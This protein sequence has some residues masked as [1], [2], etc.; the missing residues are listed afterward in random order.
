MQATQP[1]QRAKD[2]NLFSKL[3]FHYSPY[4]PLFLIFLVLSVAGAWTYLRFTT[5]IFESTAR[6]LIKDEK[7]GTE[8]SKALESL[9]ML[10]TKK[11]IENEMEVIQSRSLLTDVVNQLGLYGVVTAKGSFKDEDL[12]TSS[13]LKVKAE[14]PDLIVSAKPLALKLDTTTQTVNIAGTVYP[15]NTPVVTPWGKMEFSRTRYPV[16]ADQSALQL[17]ITNPRKV[18]EALQKNLVVSSTS[19]QSTIL[20]LSLKDPV[21]ER[22]EDVLN[23]LLAAYSRAIINDKNTL[24]AN[25]LEFVEERLKGVEHDLDSIE[26]KIQTYKSSTGAID[27]STQGKLFLENVSSND[28][29]LGEMNMQMAVLN[30]V[31]SY[32]QS[33]D[34]NAGIVPS[35]LGVSDPTLGQL[36]NK[37]YNL[38]LEY[39]SLKTTTGENSSVLIALSDQ[40]TRIKPSILENVENQRRSLMASLDNLAATNRQYSSALQGFPQKEKE[41]IDINRQREI[42]SGI[43]SF[44]LQK[45]EETALSY[46]STVPDS[47]TIDKAQSTGLPV[48]PKKKVVY[49]GAMIAAILAAMGIVLAKESLNRK[50]MFRS[51]I[52]KLTSLPI[53]G[54]ITTE[55][56][57]DPVVI[58]EDKRTFIASQFRKLRSSLGY[59][60]I[61][62]TRKRILV[63][64]AISGEGKSFVAT[65]LAISLALTG[66]KVILLDFDLNNPSINNKLNIEAAPGITDFLRGE[67]EINE[68]VLPTDIDPNLFLLP[69]GPLPKNPS[70]LIM[71]GAAEDLLNQLDALFDYIVI[72]TAPVGPVT[73]AYTLSPFTDATLYVIRHK[74]TPKVFVERLDEE[75]KIH[76]LHNAAIVF[77]GVEP[78]GFVSKNYGYGY[79]YGYIHKDNPSRRMKLL[80]K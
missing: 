37:L 57:R 13:P 18:T 55:T 41:L 27:V 67:K 10:S 77:N 1:G 45:K 48:S 64:S 17:V 43:Y 33:R 24:A 73:D 46:A 21:P 3:L 72:D 2:A 40:I 59:I 8:A 56:S 52:E 62:T 15:L 54:E 70:E 69:T 34:R 49:L 75:N 68:L 9:D 74:Y 60:G 36:V 51:E 66:K 79:G 20:D 26:R 14:N 23:S 6:I 31:Q 35:T 71:N 28:Q 78:R 53:I 11:I 29:R 76:H 19:K 63:T 32:V 39:A 47:R 16:P 4:W 61:N 30:Q 12:Y 50:I 65:N 58:H 80:R 42:K 22:S 5:P 25:T 38:E 7:K 44:L